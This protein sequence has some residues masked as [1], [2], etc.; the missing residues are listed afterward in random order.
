MPATAVLDRDPYL[1]RTLD[2]FFDAEPGASRASLSSVIGG[3]LTVAVAQVALIV[4]TLLV[5]DGPALR[6]AVAIAIVVP[7]IMYALIAAWDHHQLVA[8]GTRD[9]PY[10]F[11]AFV[12]PP[13]YL[14]LRW[15]R[16]TADRPGRI[17]GIIAG[18][19]LQ[20][21]VTACL[22]AVVAGV[23][24]ALPA[25]SADAA[26]TATLT[27]A[28]VGDLSSAAGIESDVEAQWRSLGT[29][30]QAECPAVPST[31]SG[32]EVTCTADYE[33]SRISFTVR[34]SDAQPGARPWAVVSW[35]VVA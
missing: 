22:A 26:A 21:V 29:A 12:A 30:G 1:S 7:A 8:S 31:A 9:A 17:R 27:A 33:G 4:M 19:V 34:F 23:T 32:T 3:F 2:E 25:S 11:V 14:V 20:V 35:T 16:M 5:F 18:S 15:V 28:E 6:L 13:V 10:W 24:L